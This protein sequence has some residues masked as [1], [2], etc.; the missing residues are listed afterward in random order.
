MDVT[1]ALT[2]KLREYTDEAARLDAQVRSLLAEA[3]KYK[4]A[5]EALNGKPARPAA[6][7]RYPTSIR[8]AGALK[9]AVLRALAAGHNRAGQIADATGIQENHISV[10]L[11]TLARRGEIRRVDTGL[12]ALPAT[13]GMAAE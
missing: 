11:S 3:N 7:R 8:P 12:Y 9:Q 13:N 5:I 6:E 1:Q 4:S 2:E 10:A